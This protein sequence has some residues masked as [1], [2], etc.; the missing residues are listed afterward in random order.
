MKG[1][2]LE[3]VV[4]GSWGGAMWVKNRH[5]REGTKGKRYGPSPR[6]HMANCGERNRPGGGHITQE[7]TYVKQKREEGFVQESS[8]N[9]EKEGRSS[10]YTGKFK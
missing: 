1:D 7:R 4:M 8:A 2:K 10:R 3:A 5:E 6:T 9:K